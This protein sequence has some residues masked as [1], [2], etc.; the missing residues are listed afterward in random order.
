MVSREEVDSLLKAQREAFS[1]TVSLLMKSY[2]SRLEKSNS[3]FIEL[4]CCF[5]ALKSEF[6]NQ[7]KLVVELRAE[8]EDLKTPLIETNTAQKASSERIDYL[9]DQSRRNN[10]RID[11]IEEDQ[12]E[13]WEHVAEKVKG[14]VRNKIGIQ[15]EVPI[16]RAH[17]VGKPF[18]DRPRTIVA[19]FRNFPD[20]D[21][22]LKNASKLKGS[23]LY[24]NEDLCQ[25]SRDKRKE[26]LPQLKQARSEGKIAYFVHT[27]LVIKERTFQNSTGSPSQLPPNDPEAH[28][29]HQETTIQPTYDQVLRSSRTNN[30]RPKNPAKPSYRGRGGRK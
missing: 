15:G 10:L 21:N 16:E 7:N 11:G 18:G 3:E 27:R 26:Q 9:E 22:I 23:S 25:A 29:S 30:G 13:T 2:E 17:R 12:G 6:S 14:L 5:E 4:K 28:A 8:I 20:K 19:R 1:D 24:I